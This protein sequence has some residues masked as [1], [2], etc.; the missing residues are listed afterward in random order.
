MGNI[1]GDLTFQGGLAG[2]QVEAAGSINSSN[3]VEGLI[4]GWPG[5]FCQSVR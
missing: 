2:G 5:P 4:D 3:W 1:V